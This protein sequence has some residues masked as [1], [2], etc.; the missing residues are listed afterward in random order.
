MLL[1]DCIK[2]VKHLFLRYTLCCCRLCDRCL[3][4][5]LLNIRFQPSWQ[6]R[7]RCETLFLAKLLAVMTWGM[8]ERWRNRELG[9]AATQR[10]QFNFYQKTIHMAPCL[11]WRHLWIS[12]LLF[13]W[14]HVF[15]ITFVAYS[16]LS[17]RV[18][19]H[20]KYS[21]LPEY[22]PPNQWIVWAKFT[23]FLYHFVVHLCT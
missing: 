19:W 1:I 13:Y 2:C 3:L 21:V 9:T 15:C 20:W 14:I 22:M 7:R 18:W 23:Q 17:F 10:M 4:I 6:L 8:I 11:R 16:W 5:P 12:C